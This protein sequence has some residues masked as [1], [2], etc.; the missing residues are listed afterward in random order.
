MATKLRQH[1]DGTWWFDAAQQYADSLEPDNSQSF[2]KHWI[3]QTPMEA[4]LHVAG[5]T[6]PGLAPFGHGNTA[7]AGREN[8]CYSG[9]HPLNPGLYHTGCG[10]GPDGLGEKVIYGLTTSIQADRR[11]QLRPAGAG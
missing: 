11:G 10:G 5:Q 3:G 7:L 4:E 2:Q 6:V 1:F 9:D 8:S